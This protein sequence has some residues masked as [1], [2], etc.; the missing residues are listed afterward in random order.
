MLKEPPDFIGNI[1]A[2]LINSKIT[3]SELNERMQDWRMTVVFDTDYYPVSIYFDETITIKAGIA[4]EPTLIFKLEFGTILELVERKTSMIRAILRR[5][6]KVKG[7]RHLI[8]LYRFYG[9]MN[10]ILKG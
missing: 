6:I 10:S 3:N 7:F 1:L 4:E 8:S 5:K 9:L 2:K